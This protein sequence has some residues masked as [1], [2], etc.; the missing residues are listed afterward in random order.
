MTFVITAPCIDV[1]DGECTAVCPVD[2]IYQGGR[3]YYIQP[4]EFPYQRGDIVF[5]DGLPVTLD[6]GQYEKQLG[7]LL[8][9]IGWEGFAAEKE[10]ARAEGRHIGLGLAN[11]VEGTGRGRLNRPRCG[12]RLRA[13]CSSIPARR[14]KD[15]ASR[16]RWRRFVPSRS[17]SRSKIFRSRPA[18]RPRSR[19]A[20][21]RS[22]AAK[23]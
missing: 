16:P 4:D 15:R 5:A 12:S 2:C 8:D 17:V 23:R 10:A 14:H 19:S 11:Y 18:I 9:A 7:V 1:K 20:S 21:V 22:A 3:M 6:S 13:V